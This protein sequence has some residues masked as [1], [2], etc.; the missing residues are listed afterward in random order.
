MPVSPSFMFPYTFCEYPL[1]QRLFFFRQGFI[2]PPLQQEAARTN[3]S[4]PCLPSSLNVGKPVPCKCRG[5]NRSGRRDPQVV[6]PP[7]RWW[8]VQGA[9]EVL[10]FCSGLFRSVSLAFWSFCIFHPKFFL[11]A[12]RMQLFLVPYS[13]FVF[14][15]SKRGMSR[16]QHCST[17]AKGPGPRPVSFHA[18]PHPQE[19]AFFLI[20]IIFF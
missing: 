17:A 2:G 11:I 10:C 14:C 4:F 19:T 3:N 15:C 6:C 20:F 7:L 13:F 5:V 18:P 16:C 8:C 1:E 9:C 12:A